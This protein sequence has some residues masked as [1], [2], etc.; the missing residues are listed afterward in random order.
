VTRYLDVYFNNTKTGILRQGTDGT[1]TY[2][3]D[4][5]YLQSGDA[6][7]ISFS[8]PLREEP[9]SDPVVRP[10][11]SGL[12]PDEGARQRLARALGLSSGNAFGLL[13]VIGAR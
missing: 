5:H 7:A 9:Y 12:L 13:E 1:L 3:Y 8:M 2:T 4:T 11:F 10:F 6:G